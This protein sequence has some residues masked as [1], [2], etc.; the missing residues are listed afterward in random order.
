MILAF[1]TQ[2]PGCTLDDVK[3]SFV[4]IGRNGLRER[5]YALE[6]SGEILIKRGR[7][8]QYR[9]YAAGVTIVKSKIVKTLHRRAIVSVFNYA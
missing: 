1:I 3:A 7:N 2:H 4:A 8:N 5:I 9:F 6:R